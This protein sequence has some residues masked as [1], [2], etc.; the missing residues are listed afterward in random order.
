MRKSALFAALLIAVSGTAHAVGSITGI[1]AT[2]PNPSPNESVKFKVTTDGSGECGIRFIYTGPGNEPADNTL[3]NSKPGSGGVMD[4]AFSKT[5][6]YQIKAIGSPSL[7]YKCASEA[8]LTIEVT[9]KKLGNLNLPTVCPNPYEKEPV[10]GSSDNSGLTDAQ[11][12]AALCMKFTPQCPTAF[13]S[14]FD[15]KTGQLI[16]SPQFKNLC[17][18]GWK[19]TEVNYQLICTP[20]PKPCPEGFTG[21]INKQ[22]NVLTCSPIIV[23]ECPAGWKRS[24][25]NNR[26]VC[27][28]IPQ[29]TVSCPTN[30][31]WAW[32]NTYFKDSWNK[33][34]CQPNSKTAL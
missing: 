8:N 32:G 28:S 4:K 26:L 9:R 10:N 33:M 24:I 30:D 20:I 31:Q 17:P 23:A 22:T 15:K 18:E 12:G 1:T 29:P 6:T 34:G 2:P 3:A 21:E 11:K 19:S 7:G 27:D 5:G 13:F 25:Q 14:E 16:C